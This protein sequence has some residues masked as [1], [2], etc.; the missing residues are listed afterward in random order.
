L[1]TPLS[2]DRASLK[3]TVEGFSASGSTAGHI[4][5]AWAWYLLS[6]EFGYLFA[7]SSK[8]AAYGTTNL[9]K[10][11]VIMTDG[12]Y[13]SPYCNGVIAKDAGSGSGSASDHTNCNA[14]NGSSVWQAKQVCAGMK[15]KGVV[16][17]TVGFDVGDDDTARDVLTSCATDTAHA[18]FPQ[19][20]SDLKNAF[21]EIAQQITNLRVKS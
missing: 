17:Y 10:F 16:V 13:N 6:P 18:F 1:I 5:T 19:T 11:A 4:G 15:A 14:P 20:G 2:S 21:R 7:D 12:A 3:T 9:M 8:P